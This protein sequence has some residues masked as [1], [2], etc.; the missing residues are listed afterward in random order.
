MIIISGGQTGVDRAALDYGLSN[1][2]QVGGWCPQG[3]EAEDGTLN[4]VYPVS[5]TFSAEILNRTQFNV[6]ESDATLI[7]IFDDMDEGTQATYDIAREN[8]KPV[9]VW[10]IDQN[11]NFQQFRN[12]L[13]KNNVNVLNIAGP[14]ESNAVGIYSAVLDL[15][16]ELFGVY[17]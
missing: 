1:H 16:G 9:F 17:D 10:K 13:D 2:F 5:Q 7:L 6:L 15:L 3:R 11:R 12:W 8:G 4:V 14:R